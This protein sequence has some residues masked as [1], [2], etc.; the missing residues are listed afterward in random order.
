MKAK[1]LLTDLY[2]LTMGYSYFKHNMNQRA[3]FEV[4][5]RNMPPDR[6]FLVSAG[7]DDIVEYLENF[8]FTDED[9]DYL[10][11]LRLF[12]DDYLDFLREMRFQGNMWAIPSGE[13]YFPMEPVIVI[14][15]PRI[16]AQILESAILNLFNFQSAVATKA[17]RVLIASRGR[18]CVD[19]SLRRDHDVSASLKVA[20]NSYMVGFV[21]T[22]NVLAGK[23]YNIPVFGTMAHSYI[24]SFE[25]EEQAFKT[26]AE[27]FENTTILIDTYDTLEGARKVVELVKQGYRIRAVRIDS[28][29]LVELS[30]KV[31]EIFKQA[32]IEMKIFLSGDLDEYVIDE[33]LSKG[34]IADAFGVGTRLGTVSDHPYLGGVY[35]LV[36]DEKGPKLKR[37]PGKLTL[38]GKKQVYRFYEGSAMSKDVIARY[39]E[40]LKARALLVKYFENG[41]KLRDEHLEEM[42]ERFRKS[43]E[44][45]PEYLRSIRIAEKPYKVE[46]SDGLRQ[47][48]EDLG[49]VFKI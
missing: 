36:E 32:G 25:T 20:K 46:I 19:F 14:E 13:I 8:K 12:S 10:H 48:L 47:L 1:A 33:I 31:H 44:E 24:M 23:M 15:A 37:S 11:S 42:R 17:A 5:V 18:I 9:I 39:D 21:G 26:F 3:V 4:F 43:F 45:L 29:N 6:N 7:I 27:D 49:V 30:R 38:P 16:Q 28:G 34:A 41:R 40:E 35:K 2:E 22:S